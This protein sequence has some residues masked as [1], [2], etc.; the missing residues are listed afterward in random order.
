MATTNIITMTCSAEDLEHF[1]QLAKQ[2]QS[3]GC[4]GG[5]A[6]AAAVAS[7]LLE[8]CPGLDESALLGLALFARFASLDYHAARLWYENGTIVE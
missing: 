1:V 6:R 3:P 8:D 2:G 4:S 5:E 7:A